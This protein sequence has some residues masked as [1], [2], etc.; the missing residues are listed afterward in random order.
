MFPIR[1]EPRAFQDEVQVSAAQGK[2]LGCRIRP[3]EAVVVHCTVQYLYGL[4]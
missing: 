3:G 1:N 4:K 2:S